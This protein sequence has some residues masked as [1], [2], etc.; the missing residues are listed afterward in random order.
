MFLQ[1]QFEFNFLFG[2]LN[3]SNQINLI[4]WA[5]Y[6]IDGVNF[7]IHSVDKILDLFVFRLRDVNSYKLEIYEINK[8]WESLPRLVFQFINYTYAIK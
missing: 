5:D 7:C 3:I 8:I 4:V 6:M 2:K 1:N